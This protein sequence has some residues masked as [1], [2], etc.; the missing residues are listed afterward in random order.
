MCLLLLFF[1]K[2]FYGP[3][4][5]FQ[6]LFPFIYLIRICTFFSQEVRLFDFCFDR[7]RDFSIFMHT[8]FRFGIL[9]NKTCANCL[10]SSRTK[11]LH[12]FFENLHVI[13]LEFYTTTE[14][15]STCSPKYYFSMDSYLIRVCNG[16]TL[17]FQ[18]S[19][20]ETVCDIIISIVFLRERKDVTA[21][22]LF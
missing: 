22:V 10:F 3:V 11:P 19:Q 16:Q 18:A 9:Y 21:K 17:R 2:Q 15:L 5:D 7:W 12:Y 6:M 20:M 8:M 1:V 14:V 4:S 13:S